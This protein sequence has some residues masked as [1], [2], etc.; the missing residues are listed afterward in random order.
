MAQHE[1]T[2]G[3]YYM[4]PWCALIVLLLIY[5]PPC[6]CQSEKRISGDT[7]F[8]FNVQ[9][10]DSSKFGLPNLMT[11][12]DPFHFRFSTAGR[13]IDIWTLDG[14]VYK[15]NLLVYTFGYKE[16]KVERGYT[17]LTGQL[18]DTI[19]ALDSGSARKAYDLI[20]SVRG[21]TNPKCD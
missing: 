12:Q 3:P 6:F 20:K 10:D 11:S 19:A 16:Q 13:I 17:P 21:N 4:R 18:C 14:K 1:F 7:A 9:K 5:T 2:E 8:W 15:G